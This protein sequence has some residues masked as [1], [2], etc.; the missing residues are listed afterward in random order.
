[1]SAK[2]FVRHAL[3]GMSL[4]LAA[5]SQQQV[6]ES[7]QGLRQQQ[8][9]RLMDAG[10]RDGCLRDANQSFKAYEAKQREPASP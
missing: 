4:L 8:C 9:E 7:S 3:M 5:C 2:P 6:Y 1:M 10:K